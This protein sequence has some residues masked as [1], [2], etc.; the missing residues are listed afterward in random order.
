MRSN[1]IVSI[2]GAALLIGASAMLSTAH[3]GDTLPADCKGLK[4]KSSELAGWCDATNRRK[5]NC[6]ACHVMVTPKWPE[7]FPPGGN[8]A[9]PPCCDESTRP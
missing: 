4:N 8:A 2:F 9:P 7:G 1:R 3:A 5:G 6:L